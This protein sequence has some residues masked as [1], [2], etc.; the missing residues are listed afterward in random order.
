M[1]A[2]EEGLNRLALCPACGEGRLLPHQEEREV[3]HAGHQGTITLR[4][5]VCDGCGSEITGAA[6]ML[7]NKRAMIGF[8]KLVDG[9]LPGKE[10][11]AF[12][13]RFKISQTLAARLFGGGKVGFS[14][15]E[16]DDIAQSDAMDSLIHLCMDHPAN[17]LLLARYRRTPLPGVVTARTHDQ[18]LLMLRSLA[19]KISLQLDAQRGGMIHRGLTGRE[20]LIPFNIRGSAQRAITTQEAWPRKAA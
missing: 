11:R 10:V 7:A 18:M 13:Q 8:R 14:R 4:Y 19:P 17:L 5:A 2:S 12:R 3:E 1:N 16:N 20:H 6:D 15:Y 9:L